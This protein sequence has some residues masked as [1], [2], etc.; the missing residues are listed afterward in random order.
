MFVTSRPAA[1]GRAFISHAAP[2]VTLGL[3]P[4]LCQIPQGSGQRARFTGI[5]GGTPLLRD[6]VDGNCLVGFY[7]RQPRGRNLFPSVLLQPLGHLSV[8]RINQLR[9]AG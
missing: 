6:V 4:E 9:A 8:F 2:E 3:V 7:V 5:F 1:T